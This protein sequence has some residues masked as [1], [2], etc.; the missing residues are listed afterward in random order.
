MVKLQNQRIKPKFDDDENVVLEKQID[1]LFREITMNIKG[2]EEQLRSIQPHE[3]DD[4]H[5]A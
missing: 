2:A 5:R 4:D 3:S 1:K